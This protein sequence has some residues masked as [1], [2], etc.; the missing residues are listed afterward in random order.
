MKSSVKKLTVTAVLLSLSTVLSLIKVFS[1]PLG[2]AVTLLSML[3]L[4]LISLNYGVLWSL[5]PTFLYAVI[6]FFIGGALGWGLT[7]QILVGSLFFDYIFAFMSVSLSGI[8]YKK[9]RTVLS[10]VAGVAFSLFLRFFC[11]FISGI[12]FFK[13]FDYFGGNMYLYSLVYNGSFM[14]PEL[15]LTSIFIIPVLKSKI[16]QLFY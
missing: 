10:A 16:T 12:I 9:K 7:P 15:I 4:C 5:I 2:G 14:L 3:P 13:C 6:Q 1:L 8:F 11:H